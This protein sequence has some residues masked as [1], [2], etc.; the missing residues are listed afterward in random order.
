MEPYIGEIRIFAGNFAPR[1]WAICNG[2]LL[3]IRQY[4]A[5]FSLLGTTYGGDGITTFALPDL[6]GRA[7]MHAG[8]ATGGSAHPLGEAGGLNL[9][10]LTSAN[11]PPHT[12]SVEGSSSAS[13]VGTPGPDVRLGTAPGGRGQQG[14]AVYGPPTT[15]TPLAPVSVAPTGQN[16]PIDNMKPYQALNFIIALQG[17][18][19][20]RP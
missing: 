10:T 19:P 2:A 11:L 7:P 13:N 1:D 17:V 5:L 14:P 9:V 16:Q 4:T 6:K 20:Q 3:P 18:F 15:T 12:H 8:A